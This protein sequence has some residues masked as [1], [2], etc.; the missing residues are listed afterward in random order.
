MYMYKPDYSHPTQTCVLK[1]LLT[2]PFVHLTDPQAWCV[3]LS[4]PCHTWA[5]PISIAITITQLLN[6]N[7]LLDS[8]LSFRLQLNPLQQQV[9]L[10]LPKNIFEVHSL[11]S[12]STE[13]SWSQWHLSHGSLWEPST[14]CL[15][16]HI[17]LLTTYPLYNS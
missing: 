17:H 1:C 6:L 3:P 2:S 15:F 16:I 4:F 12:I 8:S 10:C 7:A 9:L 5:F 14:W 11:L 13:P